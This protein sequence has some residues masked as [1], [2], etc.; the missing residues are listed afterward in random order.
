MFAQT[1]VRRPRTISSN[2]RSLSRQFGINHLE[3]GHED[4][5]VVARD[6]RVPMQHR[7][8]HRE[9]V[10]L[11]PDREALGSGS[12]AFVDE[13]LQSGEPDNM[14][15]RLYSQSDRA[16]LTERLL[17]FIHEG[18]DAAQKAQAVLQ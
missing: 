18:W 1:N 17:R 2:D 9:A 14:R 7:E 11:E 8:E 5:L 6:A 13:R 16:A 3:A 12:V 4:V 15:Q 10:E